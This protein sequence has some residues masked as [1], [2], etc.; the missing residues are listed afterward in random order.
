MSKLRYLFN[1]RAPVVYDLE[2]LDIVIEDKMLLLISWQFKRPYLLSIPSLKKKYRNQESAVVLKVPSH[3]DV[4]SIYVSSGWRKK[5]YKVV[6]KKLS[7]D[8]GTSQYIIQ[9]FQPFRMPELTLPEIIMKILP[10]IKKTPNP[11]LKKQK[12]ELHSLNM[13]IKS[14]KFTYPH[15]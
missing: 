8:E 4:I 11:L 12:L 13:N 14:E 9:Q 5:K 2:H 15:K 3:L 10:S 1:F 6:L 7:L